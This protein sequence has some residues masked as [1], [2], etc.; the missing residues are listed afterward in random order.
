M[1]HEKILIPEPH[2]ATKE[3][4]DQAGLWVPQGLMVQWGPHRQDDQYQGVGIATGHLNSS[5]SDM[6]RINNGG[7]KL[8]DAMMMWFTR[9]QVNAAIRLLRRARTAVYGADE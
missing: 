7:G 2:Y 1:P 4:A 3:Q 6:Q 9:S 8:E 5:D